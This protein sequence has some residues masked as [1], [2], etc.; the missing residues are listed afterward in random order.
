VVFADDDRV[1]TT[2]SA[3]SG[4]ALSQKE[5]LMR[6][7]HSREYL[8]AKL[9]N[10][11]DRFDVS[12]EHSIGSA[13]TGSRTPLTDSDEAHFSHSVHRI[14]DNV[15]TS[16]GRVSTA[17]KLKSSVGQNQETSRQLQ[18]E[19]DGIRQNALS[20]SSEV[21]PAP[22]PTDVGG[23]PSLTEGLGS[24]WPNDWSSPDRQQYQQP[25][26]TSP[27]PTSV[28]SS[29]STL[30]NEPLGAEFDVK[31][32]KVRSRLASG[33]EVAPRDEYD[34][35][36]DMAPVIAPSSLLDI[37][38]S[39]ATTNQ[40]PSTEPTGRLDISTISQF[41]PGVSYS[42]TLVLKES[43]MVGRYHSWNFN[44]RSGCFGRRLVCY[45]SLCIPS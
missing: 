22:S 39:N 44:F 42:I 41:N 1:T 18:K 32:I 16:S 7:H 20:K 21:S 13:R 25:S 5:Y 3:T 33:G 35:F 9:G 24:W 34:F 14:E 43:L 27:P 26:L 38:P 31:Q 45:C 10:A 8:T 17:L 40:V 12:T 2:A 6:H 28:R 4:A 15:R 23:S 29:R 19:T 36:A 11:D 30:S 37:L